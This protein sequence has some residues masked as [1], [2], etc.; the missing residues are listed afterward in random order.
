MK[1]FICALDNIQLGIPAEQTAQV[2]PA[3]HKQ[4]VLCETENDDVTISL[5]VLFRLNDI[6]AP[7]GIVL[8]TGS[9][10]KTVLLTPPID[11]DLEIPEEG[12]YQLPES[13]SPL[14]KFFRG[15]F[16][17]GQSIILILN[18]LTLIENVLR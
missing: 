12:I 2:I 8:K 10:G 7:H 4:T 6:T 13:L 5:T 18:P 11:I 9:P 1:Y 17:S 15:V 14:L 16:F 3:N